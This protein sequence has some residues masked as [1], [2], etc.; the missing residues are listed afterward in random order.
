MFGS[1]FNFFLYPQNVTQGSATPTHYICIYN[2][3]AFTEES[4]WEIS[5]HFSFN[6][7]NWKGAVR[8]PGCT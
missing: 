6:Y 1:G 7:Y 5:Y 2:D 3:T 8:V 4:F